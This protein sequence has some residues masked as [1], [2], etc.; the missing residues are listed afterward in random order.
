M[1]TPEQKVFNKF[2][3]TI[4]RRLPKGRYHLQRIET[5]TGTGVPDVYFRYGSMACW[6]ETKSTG[7]GVSKEQYAWSCIES[8]AGGMCWVLTEEVGELRFYLFDP[9]MVGVRL[10]SYIRNTPVMFSLSL[11]GWLAYYENNLSA[12]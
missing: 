1:S 9:A 8:A 5:S 4:A 10:G 6:I 2:K 12:C 7:Y 11:E 3:A